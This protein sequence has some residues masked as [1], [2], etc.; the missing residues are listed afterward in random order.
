[1][2]RNEQKQV[3]LVER[4]KLIEIQESEI[5]RKEKDLFCAVNLPTGKHYWLTI[6]SCWQQLC[7][8]ESEAYQLQMEALGH[9][10]AK[11]AMAEAEALRIRMIGEAEVTIKN[12][13]N[14]RKLPLS[15]S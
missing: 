4:R 6:K 1:M 7:F 8:S 5:Q 12:F 9:K 14:W 11:I 13:L 15:F 10:N 2:I 3:E